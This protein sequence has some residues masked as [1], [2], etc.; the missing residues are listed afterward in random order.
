MTICVISVGSNI[1][2]EKNIKAAEILLAKEQVLLKVSA[3]MRTAPVPP[4]HGGNY[5]NGAFLIETELEIK[6]LAL[7]L[8]DVE[9]RLGRMRSADRYAPR[10]MDLDIIV[11]NAKIVDEDY[12]RY[13]FVK[14]AVD[15]L[16]PHL[17]GGG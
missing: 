1:Q 14:K 16:L 5:L 4:A 2:P 3:F 17:K 7:Y 12:G 10:T 6:D 9:S 15:E 11:F 13:A 8:K